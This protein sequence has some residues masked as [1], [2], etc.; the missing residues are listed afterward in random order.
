MIMVNLEFDVCEELTKL[1]SLS[2]INYL[3]EP[4][5]KEERDGESGSEEAAAR[6]RARSP[7]PCA[8]TCG[9]ET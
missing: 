5:R 9:E 3:I 8:D 4:R 2:R 7:S 6:P 1:R